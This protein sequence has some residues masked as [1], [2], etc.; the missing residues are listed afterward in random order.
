MTPLTLLTGFLGAGKTTLLNRIL[1]ERH[2]VR[3]AVIVNE[4]G[5]I[6]IDGGLVRGATGDVIEL[7]NG[8][9]CC[10]TRGQLLKAVHSVLAADPPPE[11]ILVETSGLAD[12][13]PVLSELA[14]S[15]LVEQVSVDGVVTVVDAENFDRNLD[16]AEAAFQQIVAADLLLVNKVDLVSD[17]IPPLIERGLR[18]LNPT[19]GLLACVEGNVPLP[20]LVG[21]QAGAA[22]PPRD[23]RVHHHHDDFESV[24]LTPPA[25]VRPAAL[26]A[27]LEGLPSNVYRAKG[28]LRFDGPPGR[29][30]VSAVGARHSLAPASSGVSHDTLVIIGKALDRDALAAGLMACRA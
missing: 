9:L 8:C 7:A 16:S 22:T 6:G 3:M 18:V 13:F 29:V 23:G 15:S 4:F 27:W 21:T 2:G 11:G 5:E 20:V 25:M 17:D 1:T 19:A 30:E 28:H 12:P 24:A 26:A 10:A 14:H